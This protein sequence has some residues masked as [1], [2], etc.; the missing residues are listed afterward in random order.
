MIPSQITWLPPFYIN[1]PADL[2]TATALP[3][4]SNISLMMAAFLFNLTATFSLSHLEIKIDR[5]SL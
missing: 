2:A 4:E 5:L 1:C 3:L